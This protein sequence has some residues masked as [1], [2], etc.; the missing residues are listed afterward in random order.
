[1][2]E[3]SFYKQYKKVS[4][5]KKLSNRSN[6]K[7]ENNLKMENIQHFFYEILYVFLWKDAL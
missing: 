3:W 2:E 6:R 4:N 1:M 7:K 5:R